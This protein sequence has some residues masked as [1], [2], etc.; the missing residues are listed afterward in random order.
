MVRARQ[1][2]RQPRPGRRRWGDP[3]AHASVVKF[4]FGAGRLRQYV[5]VTGKGVPLRA[6]QRRGSS[7]GDAI[8]LPSTAMTVVTSRR[9]RFFVH[10]R[11][12]GRGDGLSIREDGRRPSRPK[13]SNFTKDMKNY[14]GRA[15]VLVEGAL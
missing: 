15:W 9:E 4:T 14:H 11:A 6:G 13:R 3:A 7:S 1:A 2:Y 5:T 10:Q 8:I 12:T